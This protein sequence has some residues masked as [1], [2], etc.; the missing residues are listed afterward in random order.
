MD[1]SLT[2]QTERAN[3]SEVRRMGT[4]DWSLI[5]GAAVL[6]AAVLGFIYFSNEAGVNSDA[7]RLEPA[8]GAASA[9]APA[10]DSDTTEFP[11][12]SDDTAPANDRPMP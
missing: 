7:N 2:R 3:R 4:G 5:L 8:A 12:R 9:P 10:Y 11:A 1:D 6:V